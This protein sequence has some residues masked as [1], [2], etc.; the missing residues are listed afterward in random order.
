VR[1]GDDEDDEEI[2][3]LADKVGGREDCERA[4]ASKATAWHVVESTADERMLGCVA[5]RLDDG[6]ATVMVVVVSE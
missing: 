1:L 2:L 3:A 4:L 6:V 5:T